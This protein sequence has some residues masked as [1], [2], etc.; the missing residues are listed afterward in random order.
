ML[1]QSDPEVYAIIKNEEIRQQETLSMIPSE[2]FF[3]PAVREAVGSV[4]SHKYAEGN[5]GQRYYEGNTYIDE[6]EQLTIDR[7]RAA[8][9]VP[10]DWTANVQALSGSSANLAVYLALLTTG[11]TMMAMYLPDGGHLSHGWSFEPDATKRSA[12]VGTLVYTGGSRKVNLTSQLYTVVQYKTDPATR[13]FNYDAL[14]KIAKE[15]KP[16][17]LI[18]GGTAYPRNI[19]YKRMRA[20]ADSVNAYYMADIAHEAGLIAAGVI[21]SPVGIADVV[22]MTTHKTLRSGRGAIILASRDMI[23]KINRAVLPG[24][25]GGPHNHNIAGI[26]VGLGEVLRPEF[27]SY[28][29]QV[30][31]NAQVLAAA[32][33]TLSFTIVSGGTD[34]HLV[35]IDLSDK[36]LLGKKFARALNYAGIVANANSV[37]QETRGPA[38]PSGL[39][40]GTPWLTTRGMK[41]PEMNV[42]A[43]WISEV[44]D[45]ASQWKDLDFKAF[46]EQ[47]KQSPAIASIAEQ[48]RD[49]CA[50]FPLAMSS[51]AV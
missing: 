44:M 42:I 40:L 45:S 1:K 49:L 2:N 28:A 46:E 35:L 4:M 51:A 18:T 39:R 12:D 25:Q 15:Y 13:L 10:Q 37:P 26:C 21:P 38:D 29:H 14:E 9:S 31:Q 48:V 50:R 30:V 43:G 27:K 7:A 32:L 36:P 3:S 11:D 16:K 6:L 33:T 34:K 5:V 47:V 41:E 22:T 23:K 20:I 19:D 17:L 8:F 24:L